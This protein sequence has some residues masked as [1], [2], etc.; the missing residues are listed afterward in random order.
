MQRSLLL[1]V[2]G[3]LASSA[4]GQAS[5]T[6]ISAGDTALD[7][8]SDGATVLV[9][10]FSD[11]ATVTGGVRTPLPAGGTF[12]VAIADNGWVLGVVPD[13]MSG[14]N[15]SGIY[16]PT[17]GV[18]TFLGYFE[19]SLAGC[20]DLS[21]PYDLSDD[22]LVAVGLGWNVCTAD[23]Y[24]WTGP[25]GMKQI[26]QIGIKA[27]RANVISADGETVGGW[28]E[29]DTGPRRA[30]VWYPGDVE[31]LCNVTPNNPTG[32]GEV[33]GLSDDGNW[34]CGSGLNGVGPFLYSEATGTIELG[35]APGGA[36]SSTYGQD[37]SDDGKVVVGFQGNFLGSRA[38]IWTCSGGTVFLDDYLTALG[39]AL[40]GNIATAVEISADGTQI[41]GTWDTGGFPSTKNAFLATIPAQPTWAQ[42]GVGASAV[43]LLDLDG[44]GSTGLGQLFTPVVSNIPVPATIAASGL[45]TAQASLDL[46][47]GKLLIHP[48]VFATVVGTPAGTGTVKHVIPIPPLTTIWGVSVYM[49]SLCDDATQPAGWALSNGLTV[50]I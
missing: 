21:N 13:P 36:T 29:H 47:G 17:T 43:N 27:S 5:I 45:S 25:T 28:D 20:P 32:I 23:A 24:R 41:L 39:V 31:V 15:G 7:M 38:W 34:A 6:T 1:P 18:W 48:T 8:T 2:A 3:L 37:V 14:N 22:G 33:F 40:P 4:F 42:Y 12:P 50:S 35:F 30:A 46:F 9:Q 11:W 16:Q 49:Q 26:P 19:G 44:A 10:G